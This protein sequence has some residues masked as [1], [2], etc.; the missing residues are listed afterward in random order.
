MKSSKHM[1]KRV[2]SALLVLVMVAAFIL[3]NIHVSAADTDADLWIDPVN[4]S[5]TNNGTT[6][7]T[8]L[9]TIQA[10]KTKAAD[11]SADKDVVVI[12][13]AGTYDAT[14]TI[15]F[16]E[17]DS[18]KNGH[19]I[20]YRAASGDN[21]IISGGTSLDGWTLHDAEK[22]IY[23]TDVPEG[24]ELARS[25]YVDGVVQTMAYMEQSPIDWKV[26]SSGGYK[27]PAV[28]SADN[29]EYLILDLGENKLVSGLTL[30]AGSERAGD[31]NAAGFPKDFTIQTSDDGVHWKTQVIETDCVAP[32]ARSAKAFEF[33]AVGARYIKL[34]VTE[35]GNPSRSAADKYHLAL[36]EILV[37]LTGKEDKLNLN[38]VQHLDMDTPVFTATGATLSAGS[39]CNIELGTDAVAVAGI[40]LNAS[41]MNNVRG[42][43]KV[44]A[45]DGETW[46]T[47]LNK[48]SYLFA[49]ANDIA[50]NAAAATQLRITANFDITNAEVKVYGTEK[51]SGATVTAP[52]QTA[53]KLVDGAFGSA[54]SGPSSMSSVAA[55]CDII[56][57]LGSVQD[58]GAVRMYPTYE[59]G[60]VVAYLQAA[61][62]LTSKDGQEWTTAL[63]LAEIAEP[64]FGAQL[65][66]FAKGVKAQ[67]IKIQPLLVTAIGNDYRLQLQE[68]EVVPTKVEVNENEGPQIGYK[69]VYTP[70][71]LSG[72]T[73][74]LGYYADVND[75]SGLPVDHQAAAGEDACII[76]KK[77]NSYGYSDMFNLGDLV[78]HGGTKVP[79][80]YL[81]LAAAT[82]VNTVDIVMDGDIWGA[83]RSYEVQFYDGE[84]W[85]T[86]AAEND[87]VF[88]SQNYSIH[89]EFDTINATAA[90]ILAYDLYM[91]DGTYPDDAA[92]NASIYNTRFILNEFNPQ[93]KTQI[94]YE[95]EVSTDAPTVQYDKV[96]LSSSNVLG[97]GYYNKT[98][99]LEI[100]DHK[101]DNGGKMFDGDEST[102]SSTRGQQYQ[103]IPPVGPN[104]SVILLDASAS[105][106]GNPVNINA[107]ELVVREDGRCA[108]YTYVIQ[109]T[110][111]ATEDNWITIADETEKDWSLSNEEL[112][113][114]G[115]MEVYKVRVVAEQMTPE[116]N[117]SIDDCAPSVTTYMQIA[118]LTLLNINDPTNPVADNL[119]TQGET[120]SGTQEYEITSV[121]ALNDNTDFV[122]NANKAADGYIDPVNENGFYV[123][124]K[125]NFDEL[126]HPEYVEMHTLYLWY[127]NVQHFTGM[128]GDGTEIYLET[129]LMPTWIANDYMFIDSVGEWYIDRDTCK[130]YYKADGTMDGKEAILP[131]AE[132]II[133]MDFAS[134]IKFEGITFSHTTW[135]HTSVNDYDDQQANCYYDGTKWIQVPASIQLVGCEAVTFDD[136]DFTN[137]GAAAIKIKSTG[138]KTSDGNSVINSRFH[139]IG[140]SGII[141]GEVYGHHGYQ[142]YMLVKNTT[143][144]NNYFTRVGLEMRDSPAIIATYTNGTVIEH[145]EVAF[146]PYTGI[147]TGW[148]WDSEEFTSH[149]QAFL[150]EVGNNKVI[151]NYVHDTG[152]NN[153]DGGSIYNLG[154]SKG[155]EVAYNY[156]Y[157]SWDGDDVYENG[158]YLDQGSA[159]IEVHHN[160]VGENVGYWMHQWMSTIHDNVWHDNFYVE[161]KS[162]D[163]GTNNQA[164][165]NTK[166][167]DQAELLTYPE[168]VEIMNN[169]GLLD[170]SVKDGVWEG[171]APMHDMVQEFW[172][173]ENSRYMEPDWGWED[174][175]IAGQ[176]GRTLYD[177][178][179][180]TVS[181]NVKEDTDVTALALMFTLYDGWTSDIASGTVQDFTN[182]V[183]YTLSDGKGNTVE[184][185]VSVK[186]QVDSGGEIP[187]EEIDLGT[188][189]DGYEPGQ[190]TV[191]PVA[192]GAGVLHFNDYSGYTAQYFG[193]STIFLFDMNIDVETNS[194]IAA[195]SLNN[196]DPTVSWSDGSTEYMIN[197][198]LDNIEV[199]KFVGGQRTVYYGEQADHVS[200]YGTLPNNFFTPGEVHSIKTGA[201]NTDDGGVRLFLYVDG[202]LVFDFIDT[203][204]PIRDGGH[205]AVYG[206]SQIISLR[207]HSGID[208]T[209]D[210]S[211]LDWAL[212]VVESLDV[213]DYK[214][215][216]WGNLQTAVVTVNEI[217]AS[218]GGVTQ[219]MVDQC[220]LILWEALN[221]LEQVDG[222]SGAIIPERP[223]EPGEID[224]TVYN[225]A[226]NML[227]TLDWYAYTEE[228]MYPLYDAIDAL[229]LLLDK[230]ELT[231]ADVDEV[232][233]MLVA[234][235]NGLEPLD[236]TTPPP[237]V[238]P[239]GLDYSYIDEGL[240]V[241]FSA[242]EENYSAES[243][244][245]LQDA[246]ENAY[247]VMSDF[248]C[249]QEMLN[250][251]Y[252]ALVD[253][254]KALEYIGAGLDPIVPPIRVP[255]V[256]GDDTTG[257]DTTGGNEP[258]DDTDVPGGSDDG[259]GDGDT[260]PPGKTGDDFMMVGLIVLLLIGVAGAFAAVVLLKKNEAK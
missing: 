162:R 63:E 55:D 226:Y 37:G 117:V 224:W 205:F 49:A 236:S 191:D 12:L 94:P 100:I 133:Q 73:P 221:G 181:I 140:Y 144:K 40:A 78:A 137:L 159:F 39:A 52:G 13:K 218:N 233:D 58:V 50:F 129:S 227:M 107:I 151:Y 198:N 112:Y 255:G 142:S 10:A 231:Q 121:T 155:S 206:T 259:N 65:L 199:Q 250:E 97:Y 30:Y 61:R 135:T 234:A 54:F 51:I 93:L 122:Y 2:I 201:I 158:L 217:L 152:K 192:V 194:E 17:A 138:D 187:G 44:E 27:S 83:S 193:E 157:N 95:I 207:G 130:I 249:T 21:V 110:T 185:T 258:G 214:Q 180:K 68:I 62:I 190:W 189:I 119:F 244:A 210:T 80:F 197:F 225:A 115:A 16:G 102:Y 188:I 127:H 3:P 241:A 219:E 18:G 41:G 120:A 59:N 171:F 53:D 230:D 246:I 72:A 240:K 6:E 169:A 154:S 164:Y 253:A 24:T 139:D 150:D 184:W 149:N 104:C 85:I 172:P 186:K 213:R 108:P 254:I 128:S 82:P 208:T 203:D 96:S 232:T 166:V 34:D 29:N 15:V 222:T 202:N 105:N 179:K 178:I 212:Y 46:T 163:N 48:K 1:W 143:I 247:A 147:S 243:F 126:W 9:K 47:V 238:R 257:D 75:L 42:D 215:E 183:V 174:V 11:L 177:S 116:A 28:S 134:N 161:T 113:K 109:V 118:E 20:T 216:T 229:N 64:D 67:Y 211:E 90:R 196:Q 200:L 123:P 89:A 156:I 242:K 7:A 36:S 66:L 31:G 114:F 204:E 38:M 70:I 239:E 111:S 153:R 228:S 248:D 148:G 84:N 79:A 5:D 25:F 19:T 251:A 99:R 141:V 168:A 14:E 145:N 220:T 103:W 91:T 167:A 86:V 23:V 74:H 146:C 182:P 245:A 77:N 35:L 69:D 4:G 87:V 252:I 98:E 76:D 170:E 173:G 71:S 106:G 209:P 132:Q 131:V 92:T 101:A 175:A 256:D 136:C 235:I 223:L 45:F 176:V 125:Y 56:I 8:A 22:N 165:D 43:L 33:P 88:N 81:E 260:T 26:L 160:V 124:E 57:D 32:I 195:I 60:K 237:V